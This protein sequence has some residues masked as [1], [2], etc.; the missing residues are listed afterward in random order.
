MT[1][2][3]TTPTEARYLQPGW[4]TQHVFNRAMRRL[5]RMG[6]S[7]LGLHELSVRGRSSG[8]WRTNPVNLLEVDGLRYLV[9][10]RGET[11]WVRNLRVA[12]T[13]RLRLGRRVE[14]VVAVELADADKAPILREYLRR[15]RA[16]VKVFFEG[17]DVDATDEQLA[18]VAPG[19]PAFQVLTHEV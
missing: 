16:E 15:F 10:P 3:P 7:P 19:F 12:T 18:E 8:E 17:L 14:D 6:I 5:A 4:F 9:A 13:G 2:T 11:Q 1:A